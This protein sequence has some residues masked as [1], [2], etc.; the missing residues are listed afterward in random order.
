MMLIIISALL[1]ALGWLLDIGS[2][3]LAVILAQAKMRKGINVLVKLSD[4][5]ECITV[6][7]NYMFIFSIMLYLTKLIQ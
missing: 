1:V 7:S 6:F 3:Y 5:G 2:L 4:V